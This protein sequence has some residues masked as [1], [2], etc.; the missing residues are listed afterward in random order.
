[1]TWQDDTAIKVYDYI[2]SLLIAHEES[3]RA[4]EREKH[5]KETGAYDQNHTYIKDGDW[6]LVDNDVKTELCRVWYTPPQWMLAIYTSGKPNGSFK[7]TDFGD[8]Y[9][10]DEFEVVE[11]EE[12][13]RQKLAELST[14]GDKLND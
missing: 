3:I 11:N 8:G 4:D 9:G 14:E 10:Y 12:A 6:L 2:E 7:M 5:Y 13:G 1:M